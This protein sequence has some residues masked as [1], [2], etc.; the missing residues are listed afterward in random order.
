MCFH[1]KWLIFVVF[2][3]FNTMQ[4]W[5][6]SDRSLPWLLPFCTL[7]RISHSLGFFISKVF[8]DNYSYSAL[9]TRSITSRRGAHHQDEFWHYWLMVIN[10]FWIPKHILLQ[11]QSRINGGDTIIEQC[12]WLFGIL[13]QLCSFVFCLGIYFDRSALQLKIWYLLSLNLMRKVGHI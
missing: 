3:R 4:K 9:A 2:G 1:N 12:G 11:V 6:T 13:Y 10:A 8:L 7:F 5:E